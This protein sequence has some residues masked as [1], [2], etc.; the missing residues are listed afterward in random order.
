MTLNHIFLPDSKLWAEE[1]K[2]FH[3]FFADLFYRSEPRALVQRYLRALLGGVW[4]RNGWQIAEAL[5]ERSPISV[6]RLLNHARWDADK[7]RDRLLKFVAQEFGHP[8]GIAVLDETG[9]LKKGKASVG[10][11]RQYSGTAGK[12][13]NCQIGVFLGYT[14]PRGCVLIDRALYL[15]KEWI[16]DKGRLLGAAVPK[17]VTFRTKPALGQQLLEHAQSAK[18]PLKWVTGDEVYGNDPQL[19]SWLS[20]QHVLY[21]LAVS[22]SAPVWTTPPIMAVPP[23][24]SGRGRPP[25][26]AVATPPAT[27]VDHVVSSWPAERW[28]RLE[29]FQGEKGPIRYDWGCQRVLEK[30]G[31]LPGSEVF[32]LARRSVSDP[33]ELAYY[34]CDA[35]AQT[36]VAILAW[37][38]ASR[39]TIEQ[40]FE[41]GKDDV[42]MDQYEVRGWAAWHRFITLCLLALAFVAWVKH[43]LETEHV[44]KE[45]SSGEGAPE[46]SEAEEMPAGESSQTTKKE[47]VPSRPSPFSEKRGDDGV[48]EEELAPWTV[49]E[50]RRLLLLML[51]LPEQSV[52]YHLEWMIFRL[53]HRER[54]RR[55]RYHCLGLPYQPRGRTRASQE[56]VMQE[57]V[58]L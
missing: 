20:S 3:G 50:V 55:S 34:L 31:D 32:L 12:T 48:A 13:E 43:R 36:G 23:R 21:V 18:I 7:V 47:L 27:R 19:R 42:G 16:E 56:Q 5:G 6:Q 38:A 53:A 24:R 26:R 39:F 40:L 29:I 17:E 9:F 52:E 28:T 41:E 30:V 11:A 44:A 2:A 54:A 45:G 51:S 15:P 4:R 22:C 33:K 1:F 37:V 14:S 10:V 49:S 58:M 8:D 35:P 46:V 57:Q 25:T